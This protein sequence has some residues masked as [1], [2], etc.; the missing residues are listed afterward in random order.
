[1]TGYKARKALR[2][3]LVIGLGTALMAIADAPT[4]FSIPIELAPIV[5]AAA[6]LAYRWVRELAT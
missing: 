6:L 5:S 4:D 2:D 3:L 1:M